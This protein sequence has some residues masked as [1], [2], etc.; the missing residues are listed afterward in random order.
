MMSSKNKTLI[1]IGLLALFQLL[2]ASFVALANED[3]FA[4]YLPLAGLGIF[5]F[6][7]LL[8]YVEKSKGNSIIT[9]IFAVMV[10]FGVAVQATLNKP[11]VMTII[12]YVFSFFACFVICVLHDRITMFAFAKYEK[13]CKCLAVTVTLVIAFLIIIGGSGQDG[14]RSWFN[15]FG[16]SVQLTELLKMPFIYLLSTMVEKDYTNESYVVNN[17]NL[18]KS[19]LLL[20]LFGFILILSNELG[21][22][23]VLLLVFLAFLFFFAENRKVFYAIVFVGTVFVAIALIVVYSIINSETEI[24]NHIVAKLIT[25]IG[26][27]V[28]IKD[29]TY[30][31]S[32]QILKSQEAIVIGGLFGSSTNFS[33]IVNAENDMVFPYI[34]SKLGL[35]IGLIV[36]ATFVTLFIKVQ[37]SI[38]ILCRNSENV[39]F[40][41]IINSLLLIQVMVNIFASVNLLP[42]TGIPLCLGISDGGTW[43]LLSSSLFAYV[44]TST[45][46]EKIPLRKKKTSEIIDEF[47]FEEDAGNEC[48]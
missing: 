39:V 35:V 24:S 10:L 40:C 42:L 41:T 38:N 20:M 36:F 1:P 17:K 25:R 43:M 26:S 6:G 21:T 7:V 47:Y 9:F 46:K 31:Q 22:L 5:F 33:R 45:C 27:F 32:Y 16:V 8:N 15:V 37:K 12:I 23:L 3:A 34:V 48:N 2:F 14:T 44:I 13:A 28:S 11:G 19:T 4:A 30:D 18:V 29:V